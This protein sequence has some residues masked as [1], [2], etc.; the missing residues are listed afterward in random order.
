MCHSRFA[1]TGLCHLIF[2]RK[3]VFCT[4]EIDCAVAGQLIG[5]FCFANLLSYQNLYSLF[6][7]DCLC[8]GSQKRFKNS[9]IAGNY[10][11]EPAIFRNIA[12]LTRSW[13]LRGKS[14]GSSGS[15]AWLGWV[16]HTPP[17]VWAETSCYQ[18]IER[19]GLS[20]LIRRK[21]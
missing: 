12:L 7:T 11:V 3:E 2:L 13:Q 5:A 21:M 8:T 19:Q 20:F 6:V 18:T 17:H 4:C 10:D 16:L 9:N 15:E 1:S 14:L